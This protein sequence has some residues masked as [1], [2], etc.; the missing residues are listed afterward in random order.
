MKNCLMVFLITIGIMVSAPLYARF[1]GDLNPTGRE[2]WVNKGTQ[3]AKE[4]IHD[5]GEVT[6]IN[7]VIHKTGKE[8]GRFYDDVKEETSKGIHKIGKEIGRAP[9]NVV[10]A[11]AKGYYKVVGIKATPPSPPQQSK[12]VYYEA[13]LKN[14][15]INEVLFK[16]GSSENYIVSSKEIKKIYSTDKN[17][18][19]AISIEARPKNCPSL[20]AS[21][22]CWVAISD[23]KQ[24][25]P[26]GFVVSY[27][28]YN[29]IIVTSM[30]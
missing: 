8:I 1:L 2:G 20:V 12:T 3:K 14:G 16:V 6:G 21:E 26:N 15:L 7:T 19:V 9:G 27:D 30:E 13:S 17:P 10:K 29:D 11:G 28:K 4:V 24:A 23:T 18:V 25:L 5:A 22:R